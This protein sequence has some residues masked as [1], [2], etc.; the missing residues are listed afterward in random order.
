MN[1]IYKSRRRYDVII[2]ALCVGAA[3]FGVTI[4]SAMGI[5]VG[6]E[7]LIGYAGAVASGQ[8][9]AAHQHLDLAFVIV[10]SPVFY[11]WYA[12]MPVAFVA[13][14]PERPYLAVMLVL[15]VTARIVTPLVDLRPAFEPIPAAAYTLTN[16]GLFACIAVALVLGV[17]AVWAW[18][19]TEESPAAA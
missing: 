4:I 1:P 18:A 19:A 8:V 10:A 17:R 6:A 2:R 13:L 5:P 16:L 3:L 15:T 9:V 11:P 14:V 12:V 7:F